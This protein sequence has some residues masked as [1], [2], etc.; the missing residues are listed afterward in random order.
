MQE[1]IQNWL[2]GLGFSEALSVISSW[3]MLALGLIILAAIANL[4]ARR[5]LVSIISYVVK[6][7]K[8]QWDD[9]LL[10][11]KVFSRLSHLAPAL[12]LY[13]CADFF[14][15]IS[16]YLKR[17]SVAYMALTGMSAFNAFLNAVID[18][19]GTFEM[20]RQKP[21][22]GY[23]QIV[24][25]I[26]VIAV[27][28]ITVATIMG[29][30]PW[31]L[32]TGLGAITAVI[33]L[34]F[35]DSILGLAAGIQLSANDM[36]RIGDWIEMPKYGIDGDV[37]DVSL[38]TVK[39]QNWDKTISSIPAYTLVSDT[40]KNW[41]GMSDSGG[42]RIKR[43]INIDINSIKFC[44]E[45]MIAE[46]EKIIMLSE[47][48]QNKRIELKTHNEKLGISGSNLA[49]A[50]NLTNIGTLRAYIAAYLRNHPMINKDMTFLIRQL[51]PGEHG[52]PLEIYVFSSDKD[53]IRYEGIQSDIFDHFLAAI[54]LFD[55]K[56]F[57]YPTGIDIQN[58][59]S[60]K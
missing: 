11:H 27:A 8:T 60:K 40:F 16:V 49:D 22:K 43:A 35:K 32:L 15:E 54:P 6:R 13:F 37:I 55:L 10:R 17:F 23:I 44:T 39:V 36:I 56:V 53:W 12:V 28:I 31:A 20:S 58:V 50:R 59:L 34:V 48:I 1:Y 42:R 51:Q 4:A 25:I 57:Q 45:D 29:Q 24:K 30:K 19:Y 33:M 52:L 46:F 14:P 18:I 3:I 7:S 21:I 38:H 41:R 5:I 26:G 9:I 2:T 47:Y